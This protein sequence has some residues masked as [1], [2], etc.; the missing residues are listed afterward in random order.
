MKTIPESHQYLI[1]GPYHIALSTI[2]PDGQPQITP[3]WCNRDGDYVLINTMK[4]FRK[5]KNM[6][7]NPNVTLF[8][9][10]PND[11]LHNIEIRGLVVEMCEEGAVEHLDELTQLYLGKPDAKF[12]GDS[13]P[14]ELQMT[15]IPV[16]IKIVP[17]HIRVERRLK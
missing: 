7:L 17:T 3:I 6:R 10:D 15:H 9:Y 2:M 12:F 4:G 14:P 5:E 8:A 11:P 16:R 1:D 13:V